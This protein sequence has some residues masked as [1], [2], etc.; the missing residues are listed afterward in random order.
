MRATA[1]LCFLTILAGCSSDGGTAGGAACLTLG[2]GQLAGLDVQPPQIE[3]EARIVALNNNFLDDLGINLPSSTA[4]QTDGGGALGGLS[5]QGHDV[6]VG[7]D[8]VGGASGVPQ[9]MTDDFDGL[10]SIVNMNFQSPFAGQKA[11]V[12]VGLPNPGGCVTCE[13]AATSSITGFAGGAD[14]GS[15]ASY[16]PLLAGT[17][18]FNILDDTAL[19]ALLDALDDDTSQVLI[20]P[21]VIQMLSGQRAVIGMQDV[22]PQIAD[23][24]APFRTAVTAVVP[25]PFGMFTGFALDVA[26]VVNGTSIEMTIR[27]GTKLLSVFRSVPADVGATPVDVEIPFI[28]PSRNYATIIVPDGQTIVI[29]ALQPT[30]QGQTTGVPLLSKI[31][32]IGSLFSHQLTNPEEQTLVILITPRII[33]Q[34]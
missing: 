29:G 33:S 23:L 20:E 4:V 15:L 30:G 12:F 21:P 22:L 14:A 3:I 5:K 32:L 17:L 8:T 26:P 13:D 19:Q 2:E 27:P 10:L 28:S 34:E 24:E 18:F 16:D 1:F 9:L 11:K 31:P 6:V 7:S 25:A